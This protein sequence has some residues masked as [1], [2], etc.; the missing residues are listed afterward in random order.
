MPFHQDMVSVVEA[1]V[2]AF[3]RDDPEA[4]VSLFAADARVEDPVGTPPHVGHEAIRTF[5]AASMQTGARLKLEGPVRT[6]ADSAAFAFS[7]H[8]DHQGTA[9]RIDVIDIFRFDADGKVAS[10]QAYFGPANMTAGS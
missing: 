7:V 5:Y 10:M 1:Y 8:L 6:T 9:L 4:V 3:D 2:S